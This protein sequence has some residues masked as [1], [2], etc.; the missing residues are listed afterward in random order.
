MATSSVFNLTRFTALAAGDVIP[1]VDVS[2]TT[3]SANGS[4]DSIT[5]TNFFA[6]IP[7][8]VNVTSAS[9]TA[10]AV[11]R[12]GATTPAFT[13]DA[14]TGSQ[15]AG[16]K[17]TGAVTGGT[18][19]VVVTDSGSNANLTVNAKGTGTIGIGSVSTGAVT[20]TPATTVTGVLTASTRVD[21]DTVRAIGAGN[22]IL[23][24]NAGTDLITVNL[25]SGAATF[26]AGITATTGTFSGA[27]SG[28]TITGTGLIQTTVTTQ[29]L[30]LKYDGSNHL[31][32]TVAS[33]GAVTYDATGAAAQHIFSEAIS[34]TVLLAS[35]TIT[36]TG[37]LYAEAGVEIRGGPPVVGAGDIG[38]GDDTQ[39]T[40]GGAG[41][42]SALPATP[43]GYWVINVAGT[44]RVIP[45][46][47]KT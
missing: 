1:A 19:A 11:G 28:T 41:G 45:F 4:L 31:A 37:V 12:L 17:V 26:V 20:I 18:V 23:E 33:N 38:L 8:P 34:C 47:D 36:A 16:L 9:A 30:A 40:V 2:D 32:V 46:Y 39:T 44:D 14:S 10:L 6:S 27:V 21:T 22:W 7:A 25:S 13:V 43:R 5:V 15:V 42:A 3:Q 24:N 29:Q 35:S